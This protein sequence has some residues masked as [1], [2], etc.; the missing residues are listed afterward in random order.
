MG[1]PFKYSDPS[2]YNI[3]G[4]VWKWVKNATSDVVS[5]V[6]KIA[7]WSLL[8]VPSSIDAISS[9]DWSRLDPFKS[10][11]ISN[12]A[13]KI[14]AGLFKTDPNR[15][16]WDR[17][18]QLISR[19]TFELPQT[20]IG[21]SYTQMRNAFGSVDRVDYLGGA[22]FATNENS[23]KNNGI[24]IGSYININIQEKISGDFVNYVISHPMYMHEYGHTID[25][26]NYGLSFLFVIGLPSLF[27]CWLSDPLPINKWKG[28]NVDN[29]YNVNDH[30]I[31]WYEMHAN[32]NASDY[33]SK[34]YNVNWK[35]YP[36]YPT[37]N[38]F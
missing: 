8:I 32:K 26:E 31:Q 6:G 5:T 20:F 12:N 28:K 27:N 13:Y 1:N 7:A 30:D 19:F 15:N 29:P 38:P 25:S 35:D 10:G 11:T 4:D 22:T 2:G 21:F 23:D 17:S 14:G 36:N 37:T 16:F 24:T 33:F 9:G 18:W 3:F 34:Y